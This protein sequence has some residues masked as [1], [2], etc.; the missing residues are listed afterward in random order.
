MIKDDQQSTSILYS[1]I[2][3]VL[4][5]VLDGDFNAEIRQVFVDDGQLLRGSSVAST[6]KHK[7]LIGTVQGGMMFC[8]IQAF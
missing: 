1:F 3:Q 7:M 2:Q 5:M 4:W 6:Y 8:H